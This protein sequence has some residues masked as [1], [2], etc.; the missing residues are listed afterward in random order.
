MKG[1]CITTCCCGELHWI[2]LVV[3]VQ[4]KHRTGTHYLKEMNLGSFM[5]CLSVFLQGLT[6]TAFLSGKKMLVIKYGLISLR[7]LLS[8]STGADQALQ[9]CN[10]KPNCWIPAAAG[11]GL[12]G[13][14]NASNSFFASH[15]LIPMPVSLTKYLKKDNVPSYHLIIKF[16]ID[17]SAL[18]DLPIKFYEP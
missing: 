7:V 8:V 13:L 11:Q 17:V 5:P 18:S 4:S 14:L 2:I 16:F 12:N 3:N 9:A 1:R 6:P 15:A 10:G